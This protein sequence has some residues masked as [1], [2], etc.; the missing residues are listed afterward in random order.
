VPIGRR[1]ARELD[2]VIPARIGNGGQLFNAAMLATIG[3]KIA[4]VAVF[5]IVLPTIIVMETMRTTTI[6]NGK[7]S[8][9]DNLLPR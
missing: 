4:A 9:T 2:K 5:D 6:G 3:M 7:A 1:K 8:T